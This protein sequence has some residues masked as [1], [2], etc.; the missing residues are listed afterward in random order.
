MKKKVAIVHDSYLHHG[1]AEVVLHQLISLYPEASIFIPLLTQEYKVTLKSQSNGRVIAS[2][3]SQLPKSVLKSS[4]LKPFVYLYFKTLN[5]SKYDLVISSSHSYSS[6]SV[7]VSKPTPHIS[8]IHT[9]P[10][11][12]Y[13]IFNETSLPIIPLLTPVFAKILKILARLDSSDARKPDILIANS[14]VIQQRIKRYYQR[15]SV[16]IYPPIALPSINIH[17]KKQDYYIY[18]GRLVKQKGVHLLVDT[19]NQLDQKLVIIGVGAEERAL[20]V[21]A[22]SNITFLGFVNEKTKY[23][24]LQSAKA[25]INCSIEEDFGIAPIEA[26]ACGTPVIAYRSGALKETIAENTTGIFFDEHSSKSLKQ[27]INRFQT[28]PFSTKSCRTAASRYA[29]QEFEK[30]FKNIVRDAH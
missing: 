26:L 21:K 20:K 15:H 29:P 7:R 3:L 16:V 30:Q 19:F 12:L 8:Y 10:R 9:P 2:L 11:Y 6:K 5:L 1:G 24:K 13:D 27:A 18:V 25:Y 17:K 4:W 14:K 23:Q 22:N 28:M